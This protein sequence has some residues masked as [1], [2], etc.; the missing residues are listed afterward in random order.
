M[1]Y[2]NL[3]SLAPN[4]IA[5]PRIVLL[6]PGSF[7]SAYFEHTT[8]ARLMGIKLV[9]GTDLIVEDHKVYMK[10]TA[11]LQKVEV[12]YRRVEEYYLDTLAFNPTNIIGVTGLMNAYRNVNVTNVNAV[13]NG[14][15]DY[16][17]VFV[18]VPDM[19]KN[20]LN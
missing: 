3:L 6:S 12:I 16:I 7:N 18:Y 5:D 14:V 15:T 20:Y 9:E 17:A 11:G 13:G 4:N 10:T 1:L 8:L 19:I 2:N